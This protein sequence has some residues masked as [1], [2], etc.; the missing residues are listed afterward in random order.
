MKLLLN[1]FF[2]VAISL[3]VVNKFLLPLLNLNQYQVPYLNDML[4]LPVVLTLALWLQQNLF[5]RSCRRRL[6]GAQ[7]IFTVI[8][9]A[10]IFEGLLPALSDKYTRDYLDVLAYAVGG[11]VYYFLLNPKP[12]R[13]TV[14]E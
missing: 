10:V 9:F 14:T 2:I 3:Y 12:A 5:P 13:P 6:N 7:V 11:M 1:P 4:C 8:Y